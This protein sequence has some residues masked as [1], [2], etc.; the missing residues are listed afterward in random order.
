MKTRNSL[1]LLVVSLTI[2]TSSDIAA[3]VA[4]NYI[5]NDTNHRKM[6]FMKVERGAGRH[7]GV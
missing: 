5:D 4:L 6:Y 1:A 3:F 2:N 7:I